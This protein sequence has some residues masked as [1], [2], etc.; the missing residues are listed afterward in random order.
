MARRLLVFIV[1]PILLLARVPLLLIAGV[2]NMTARALIPEWRSVS[3]EVELRCEERLE[4]CGVGRYLSLV[5]RWNSV[6]QQVLLNRG[7]VA[8]V[9]GDCAEAQLNWEQTCDQEPL[10]QG[11]LF[12]F[13]LFLA[14]QGEIGGVP[15]DIGAE[16]LARYAY[17]DG[18]WAEQAGAEERAVS[19]YELSFELSPNG[20]AASKLAYLYRQESRLEEAVAVWQRLAA[21]L[22]LGDS[23]HWW[24]LGQA[25]E[26]VQEWEQAAWAY[27]R[28][29]EV[30]EE[31]YDFW[32]RKAEALR[33]LQRWEEAEQAH[34]RAMV[35]RP[36]LPASYLSLGHLRRGLEDYEGARAWYLR[37]QVVAPK[38]VN[39]LYFLGLTCYLQGQYDQARAW[40]EAALRVAPEHVESTYQL[41]LT[42]YQLGEVTQAKDLLTRAL[43]LHTGQPWQ[44]AVQLGDWR[45]ALG[46]REGALAAYRQALE[47]RPGEATIEGRIEQAEQDR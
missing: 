24:A 37:A 17:E 18:R 21:A 29:I 41:A 16:R 42:L 38:N 25:A 30:A 36:D 32:M 23:V 10:G 14:T 1:L 5:P 19:S 4:V 46:D 47:W 15:G 22:P 2:N 44:W 9:E 26:V 8:W 33:R 40:L 45:L 7:R 6:S 12:C 31:P 28:G 13:W 20:R 27:G 11:A 39:P 43:D 35:E 34:G 3:R